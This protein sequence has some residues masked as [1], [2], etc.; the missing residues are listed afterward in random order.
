MEGGCPRAPHYAWGALPLLSLGH[1]SY[2]LHSH[3]VIDVSPSCFFIP[4]LSNHLL[5]CCFVCCCPSCPWNWT[6]D[7]YCLLSLSLLTWFCC[8]VVSLRAIIVASETRQASYCFTDFL[9]PIGSLSAP[10][11]ALPVPHHFLFMQLTFQPWR[12]REHL[13]LKRQ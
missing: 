4:S 13:S 6:P 11:L 3:P 7:R 12:L 10:I 9:L 2:S 1:P 8:V 5:Y